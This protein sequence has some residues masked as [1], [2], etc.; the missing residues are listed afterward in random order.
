MKKDAPNEG[1]NVWQWLRR[2]ANELDLQEA[3][4]R[5]N[6]TFTRTG[7]P[8]GVRAATNI[9]PV[10]FSDVGGLAEAKRELEAICVA[11]NNPERYRQWGTRPPKGVLLYGPPGTGKT[12]LAR[13]VAG[14]AKASFFHVRAVDVASMWYGQAERRMQDAFDRARKE[15][16]AVVFLDEVDALTPPREQAH[17]ATHRVIS[18]LLENLDG[19]RPLQGVVV[20][21]ATN[22]PES[23][24]SALLRPGR[25]D[26]L[27]EVP[28]PDDE[29]R[30]Q[31]LRVHLRRAE[32]RA[33]R[34]LFVDSDWRMAV[35]A[36]EGMSG[37]EIEETVRR[38]LESRVR[39]STPEPVESLI[40]EH[41][42]LAAAD[43]FEWDKPGRAQRRKRWWAG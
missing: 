35:R 33:R 30:A 8:A 42:L 38:T 21:A 39:R 27:V 16:P 5:L 23:V 29:A 20:I 6:R 10:S 31:I 24:D 34:R 1:D 7:D 15:R 17:E 18:T 25:L 22:T 40:E 9:P 32:G 13:C 43:S 14:Q 3:A 4:D 12:L 11:L 36:T 28:L 26:R 19:L 37:A 41:E 2:T